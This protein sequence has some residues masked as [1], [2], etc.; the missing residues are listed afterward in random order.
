MLLLRDVDRSATGL[1]PLA[2]LWQANL[3]GRLHLAVRQADKNRES[4]RPAVADAVGLGQHD[5]CCCLLVT[6][7]K[8][9]CTQLITISHGASTTRHPVTEV[10][11][12]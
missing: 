3:L 7:E 1:L 4:L 5:I 11:F 9:P 6:L 10:F 12:G 2:A 8:S